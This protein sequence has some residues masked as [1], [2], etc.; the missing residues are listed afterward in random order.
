LCELC[1]ALSHAMPSGKNK[2]MLMF[3]KFSLA[4]RETARRLTRRTSERESDLNSSVHYE[5]LRCCLGE[6]QLALD[7]SVKATQSAAL[8]CYIVFLNRH[9]QHSLNTHT[10]T[11]THT[12]THTHTR[13]KGILVVCLP[14]RPGS[15]CP[16]GFS[17]CCGN[18]HSATKSRSAAT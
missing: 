10:H 7:E 13:A 4:G 17:A 3:L 8:S 9:R 11:H 2:F 18:T 16:G 12:L 1:S 14:D 6:S 5:Y 15:V